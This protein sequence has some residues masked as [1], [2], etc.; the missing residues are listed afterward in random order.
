MAER[1]NFSK[2][3]VRRI[4]TA[5]DAT[6][7]RRHDPGLVGPGDRPIP[8][9]GLIR[10]SVSSGSWPNNGSRNVQYY[11]PTHSLS[12]SSQTIT[13]FNRTGVDPAT[14]TTKIGYCATCEGEIQLIQLVC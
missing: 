3:G 2:K 6:E 5:V 4:K 9:L 14:T 8:T 12:A 11:L 1:Y 7:R 13:V 10:I